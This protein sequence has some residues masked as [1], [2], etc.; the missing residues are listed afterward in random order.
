MAR[1]VKPFL[2]AVLLVGAVG[3]ASSAAAQAGQDTVARRPFVEGGVY[4]KP[5]LGRLLGRTAVGGY[6]EAHARWA[7]VDGITEEAGFVPKRFNLFTATQVSDWVRVA[8]ELEFEEGTEEILLEFAAIDVTIHPAL[9]LR[10]GMILSPLGRFNLSHDSPLNPFTDRPLVSTDLLGVALSEPGFGLFGQIPLGGTARLTYEAYAVNGF[11][12]GVV[13]AAPEGTRVPMG[14]ANVEDTNA[15]PALVGRLAWSPRLGLELGVSA[16][17][18][19]WN[20]FD[21][22]GEAVD[23]R[24]DLTLAVVDFEADVAGFEFTGEAAGVTIDLPPGLEGIH[25]TGQRG[26]F[27]DAVRPFGH[28]WV[29]TMPGASF[30]FKMRLEMVDFDT[31]LPGDDERRIALGLNFRPTSDT[32]LKLDWVR[33]RA[34]DRFENPSDHA[35][36]LFSLA[37]YF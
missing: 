4:D 9:A 7:R 23:A 13:T 31:D 25:A 36:L 37:T 33:A 24:R 27:V 14:R 20:I 6:A 5:Y 21:L 28:G 29:R 17:H 15:S 35:A 19:A 3:P 22:E 1:R 10:G 2:V 8:A 34:R 18:G 16:H 11:H 30:A 26:L 32:V 12:D